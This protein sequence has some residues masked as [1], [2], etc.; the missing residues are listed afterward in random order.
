MVNNRYR[1]TLRLRFPYAILPLIFKEIDWI[2]Y[3]KNL[4]YAD[5]CD[6]LFK[7]VKFCYY[8]GMDVI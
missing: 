4:A 3:K 7:S 1:K 2:Y 6:L 8:K 5:K